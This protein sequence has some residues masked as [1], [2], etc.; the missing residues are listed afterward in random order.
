MAAYRVHKSLRI[1][2]TTADRVAALREAGESEARTYNR[3]LVAGLD[4]LEGETGA[5]EIDA[6]AGT[7]DTNAD[8][9]NAY[10]KSLTATLDALVAQL[11]AKDEQ[12][13]TLGAIADRAQQLN[14]KT[15]ESG[16]RGAFSHIFS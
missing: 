5:A 8:R 1:D 16:R 15:L 11:E 14:E 2:G 7:T 10:I 9:D 6:G 3:V 4:V 12:I 13:R